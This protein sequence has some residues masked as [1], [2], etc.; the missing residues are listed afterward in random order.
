GLYHVL[1]KQVG[2]IW[3]SFTGVIKLLAQLATTV[4]YS[5]FIV[6]LL[7]LLF[8][9]TFSFANNPFVICIGMVIIIL[10]QATIA[11]LKN[12][13]TRWMQGI[14]ILL[15]WGLFIFLCVAVLIFILPN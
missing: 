11:N 14:G 15:Y 4:L 12:V 8:L 9:N 10:L 5:I 6:K 2:S 13:M 1:F 3:A 7:S